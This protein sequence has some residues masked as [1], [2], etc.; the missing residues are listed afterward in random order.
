MYCD[1]FKKVKLRKLK[2]ELELV[3]KENDK[4]KS[5][6]SI[7]ESEINSIIDDHKKSMT[8]LK[9]DLQKHYTEKE[10]ILLDKLRDSQKNYS[11]I[12]E[13]YHKTLT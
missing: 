2:D 12:S 13:L 4:L 6:A 11:I 5:A 3:K 10:I 8:K 1:A 7:H 9:E